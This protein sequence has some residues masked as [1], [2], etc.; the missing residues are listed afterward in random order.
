MSARQHGPCDACQLVRH[1]DYDDVLGCSG[2]ESI[3]P[4]SDGRSISLDAQHGSS[5]AMN[6]HLAQIDVPPLA[7]A[8][9]LRLASGGVLAWHDTKPCCEVSP[10]AE[11]RSVADRG[12][13]GGRDDG[14]DARDLTDTTLTQGTSRNRDFL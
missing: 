13:D 7:D 12:N 9:Q 10:L 8:E 3:Q 6:Q 11:C 5:C 1:G 2:I 14:S 4:G